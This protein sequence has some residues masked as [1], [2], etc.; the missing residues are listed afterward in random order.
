MLISKNWLQK[1]VDIKDLDSKEIA[2]ALTLKTVEVEGII[3]SDNNFDNIVV[4]K[5]ISVDSHP[6]ADKLRVCQ[7]DVG[8][9]K[10]EIVCGGSNLEVGMLVAVG[11][12][13]AKV[14][15][16]GEGDLVELKKTKIR[17]VESS[18]MICAAEEIGLGEVFP[19][20]DEKEILDLSHMNAEVG[21]GLEELFAS[22]DVIFEVDNKSLSNRP[23]L[24]GHYGMAR[25]ISAIFEK[26]LKEYKTEKIKP[27][28]SGGLSV[29]V[30]DQ[31]LCPRYMGVVIHGINVQPSPKW[32]E[33][34]LMAVG[35]RPINNIVDI[36]N[37]VMLELGQ[38]M[39]AFDFDK[40]TINPEKRVSGAG[41]EQEV[42]II[43]RKA[44]KNEKIKTLDDVERKLDENMLVI[45]DN[46]KALA[47]AGVM[48]GESS[49][50][51]GDT[52]KI[53]FES[54]NFLASSV[55]TTSTKLG[56]RTDSSA[57]FE[58][59]LDP[60]NAKLALEKA[61]ELVLE[62]C[63]GARVV[64][65]VLDVA[66]FIVDQ[67]PIEV[68]L[69][70]INE[71]IG[72]EVPEKE[73]LRI[74][75][76]LGF[77]IK[78]KKG[79]L[80]I[81]IPTWRATRDISIKE[82]I[83]EEVLR[84]YGYENVVSTMPSASISSPESNELRAL[85]RKFKELLAYQFGY[86]EV[87]N[88]S[89]VSR[90][91]LEKL[92]EDTSKNLELDNPV[93]KDRPLV[94]RHLVDNMLVNVEENLHRFEEVKIF[95]VGKVYDVDN[96]GEREEMNSEN[97]LPKQDTLLAMMYA[98]KGDNNPF[99]EVASNFVGVMYRLGLEADFKKAS[100]SPFVHPGRYAEVYVKGVRVG[101]IGELNSALQE[102]IGVPY[103][104]GMLEIDLDLVLPLLFES[105][106]YQALPSYP[107]SDRD[108]A[109]TVGKEVE[110]Q[111][112][113]KALE[114]LD[115]ILVGAELFDVYEGN[116]VETGKKSMA[117]HLVYRS[118]EKT[119]AAEEVDRVH[120]KVV[121][122]LEKKFGVEV[123]K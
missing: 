52:N 94:R 86:D 73:I 112:I 46:E 4:G 76:R 119:L 3:E 77:E 55:R 8:D 23:D 5:I 92:G 37:Y 2:K 20:K 42:N 38:P 118:P 28:K 62:I 26:K 123:R 99:V 67:G 83:V 78:N 105:S 110:H 107:S 97:Y 15:W 64:S 19:K 108:I 6:D 33:D 103:R 89:F 90:E 1:F 61:V 98:K 96:K 72:G 54:A 43:V 114:G 41:K 32:L 106:S 68:P 44:H 24:W 121:K 57:R 79:N 81:T 59:S 40:L 91:W 116:K 7:V 84:I 39:H 100:G 93:A 122:T 45:A 56:L 10:L 111:D 71:K 51:D 12:I 13:G 35:M 16:H 88:Y 69:E 25:E 49:E 102:K 9:G 60:N 117:Y 30:E 53:I 14:K 22:D 101:Q 18:G 80:K 109:F 29:K 17:G 113:K 36:T 21:T 31:K 27:G 74:L 95:E 65:N 47:I 70:F 50:I 115:P 66:N 11:K 85:E 58:K 87:Y 120:E 104:V 34:A 63:P 48:G 82:D 75:E